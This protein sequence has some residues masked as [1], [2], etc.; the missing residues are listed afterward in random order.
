[1]LAWR[2]WSLAQEP[3]QDGTKH[4][5]VAVLLARQMRFAACKRTL[6]EKHGLVAHFSSTHT[7]WW[8]AV[9]YGMESEK[10]QVVDEQPLSWVLE[11]QPPMDLF[12]DSQEPYMAAAWRE[13]R[14][15]KDRAA[16]ADGQR[17][18]FTKLD[19]TSLVLSKGLA[20]KSAVLVYIRG[21]GTVAMQAWANKHQRKI[22]EYL[23]DAFEWDSAERALAEEEQTDWAF[24]CSW[25]QR[26]CA[27]GLGCPYRVAAETFFERNL[28]NFSKM[29]LAE[30]LRRIFVMGPCKEARVPFLVGA[31]NT[32]KST[33]V[34]S[35]D[36][37][38]GPRR[39]Y[40]L[41]AVTDDKF[42]LRNWLR[43]KRLVM[44]DEFS[45]V[46]FAD[47]GVLPVTQFKKAFNGQWFEIRLPQGH[48]DGNQDFRWKRGAVFTNKHDDLWTPTKKVSPEDIN[49]LKSRCRLFHCTS[50]FV[51]PGAS[52]PEIPQC[53]HH[54][55]KWICEGA[56]AFDAR[57]SIGGRL[58]AA[59]PAGGVEGLESL[60][61]AAVLPAEVAHE[62]SLEVAASG[63][64][65]VRELSREDWIGLSA[66]QRL[67]P[68]EQRRLLHALC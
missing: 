12:E 57:A 43:N 34:E 56:A 41:P 60:L 61:S 20:T 30:A 29:D 65:H 4:F 22:E 49:H 54:L 59:L 36:E 17:Q 11:G 13:R 40:H 44:W 14:E 67:R 27:H 48:H 35:F 31:T 25:L 2:W 6:L 21:R 62:V 38:F 23:E 55:A 42:P 7:Q 37:L 8:S 53:A 52:R 50:V 5:H 47:L 19:F 26:P 45:P 58:V 51:P 16:S 15:R 3:H 10:K 28:A 18:G 64:L 32:G 24:L 46:E 9:R 66:W 68:M 39:V 33:L 63:A 1:M